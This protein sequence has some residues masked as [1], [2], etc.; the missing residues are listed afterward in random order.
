MAV[1]RNPGFE[2][3]ALGLLETHGLIAAIEATDAMLKAANVRLIRQERTVP[4]LITCTIAGETAAVRAAI[5]AGRA[6]A[7]RVGRVVSAHVIPRPAAD[8]RAVVG[9]GEV[10]SLASAR[11]TK[12]D[13]DAMTVAELRRLARDRADEKFS[14]RAIS[15]ASKGDLVTFLRGS[16]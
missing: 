9:M 15:T 2:G 13:Y 10:A 6:A 7:E 5:D 14:G 16:G 11:S 1:P 12:T 3:E 4:A 8:V